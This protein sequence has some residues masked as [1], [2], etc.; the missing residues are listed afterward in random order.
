M[1]EEVKQMKNRGKKAK[2]ENY[3]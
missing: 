3:D 2:N 1:R